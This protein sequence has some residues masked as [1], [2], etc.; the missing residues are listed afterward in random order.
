M[1]KFYALFL[2]RILS[3]KLKTSKVYLASMYIATGDLVISC[4]RTDPT[5]GT[6]PIIIVYNVQVFIV[7][8]TASAFCGIRCELRRGVSMC[9]TVDGVAVN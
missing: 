5:L 8:G 1:R 4:T 2:T 9:Y 3:K 6:L 7:G